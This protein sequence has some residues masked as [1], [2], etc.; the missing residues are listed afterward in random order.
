[1]LVYALN[2]ANITVLQSNIF[3]V[4]APSQKYAISYLQWMAK[5]LLYI[6]CNSVVERHYS[7]N[8]EH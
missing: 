3:I 4:Y 2:V 6:H 8:G 7:C 1:M 5:H